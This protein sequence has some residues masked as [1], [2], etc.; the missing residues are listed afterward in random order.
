MGK[1]LLLYLICVI[2]VSISRKP[3]TPVGFDMILFF[4]CLLLG[5]S[6]NDGYDRRDK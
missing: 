5:L 2:V 6:I 4:L 1:G 3:S